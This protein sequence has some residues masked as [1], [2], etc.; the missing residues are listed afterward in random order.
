MYRAVLLVAWVWV[1]ASSA[2][3]A[4]PA[5]A[6]VVSIDFT[7]DGARIEQDVPLEELEHAL[8]L[9][10]ALPGEAP[11]HTVQRQA[12]LLR[13]YASAHV[14]ASSSSGQQA[15]QVE[16]LDVTGYRAAD[17]PRARFRFAL[18]APQGEASR[19]I[20]L[21]DDIVVHQVVSHAIAI[22]VRSDWSAGALEAQPR[23]VATIHAGRT[24]VFIPR[25]GSFSQGLR[26]SIQLGAEHITSGTDHLLFLFTL[27]LVAPLV[28][29]ARR[30]QLRRRTGSAL[31]ALVK[32]V[33]AFTIGHSLTLALGVFEIVVPPSAPVEAGIAASILITAL[34][35]LRP[36][37]PRREAWLAGTFGLIHGLA[38]ASTLAGRDLGRAQAA[39]TLFGFNLGIELAQLALLCLVVPWLLLLARTRAYAGFRIAGASITAV[40]AVAWLLERSIG[41]DNPT[42]S[43]VAWL[44]AHALWLL[45]GLAALA[46]TA[47]LVSPSAFGES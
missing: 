38:F 13:K 40:L 10:L 5:P 1:N 34:H 9:T 18:R 39:W 8:H 37:L 35:A 36:L 32:V 44:E 29:E 19:S 20:A 25:D 17:G 46:I 28:P 12:E 43:T 6:S 47:R 22:F 27:V 15:W 16:M 2:A 4:H 23:L 3:F 33:S 42:A 45:G 14:R 41:V 30:W 26:S 7:V 11:A 21:H 31:L 24:D